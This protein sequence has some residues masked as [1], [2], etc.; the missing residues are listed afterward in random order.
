MAGKNINNQNILILVGTATKYQQ[1][2]FPPKKSKK[3]LFFCSLPQITSKFGLTII[4]SFS[5]VGV[6]INEEEGLSIL[7][8]ISSDDV[9]VNVSDNFLSNELE[10]SDNETITESLIFICG[11]CV[12]SSSIYFNFNK[13]E[14]G[15]FS[16]VIEKKNYS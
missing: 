13:L 3:V 2:N 10:L 1:K 9:T 11:F 12:I 6:E 4:E 15:V 7:I 5:V 16:G 8:S 14:F